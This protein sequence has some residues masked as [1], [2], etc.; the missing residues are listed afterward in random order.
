[1]VTKEVEPITE[2]L[3]LSN[4]NP[5]ALPVMSYT[6]NDQMSNLDRQDARI[7]SGANVRL[8]ED[9]AID[10]DGQ[11]PLSQRR[12]LP[13]YLE[14]VET[15]ESWKTEQPKFLNE[16]FKTLAKK[17]ASIL[18][19]ID[20]SERNLLELFA[21]RE[22]GTLPPHFK[23]QQKMVDATTDIQGKKSIAKVF[24]DQ[25]IQT[26]EAKKA[27]LA[28][29]RDSALTELNDQ[30]SQIAQGSRTFSKN[31][32]E[33]EFVFNCFVEFQL[34]EFAAKQLKDKAKKEAK[35]K[36]FEQQKEK[37]NAPKILLAHEYD[38][39]VKKIASLEIK[40]KSKNV[41]GGS[42]KKK[43]PPMPKGKGKGKTPNKGKKHG[44]GSTNK[45]N[46]SGKPRSV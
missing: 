32:I 21:F 17:Q 38:K 9:D 4:F 29:K 24:I 43:T 39:L 34:Y 1:L 15:V 12:L 31:Q 26:A 14:V 35:T 30:L 40:L 45:K 2:T 44:K 8:R 3:S 37:N 41:K 42:M 25:A 7:T 28:S 20:Q 16:I 27:E 36:K 10:V 23:L 19:A 6:T 5:N 46:T 22:N 11:P 18:S 13:N 33:I